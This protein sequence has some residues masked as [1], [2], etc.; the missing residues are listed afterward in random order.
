LVL[1]VTKILVYY[2][3]SRYTGKSRI[4]YCDV[5]GLSQSFVRTASTSNLKLAAKNINVANENDMYNTQEIK[6]KLQ[7]FMSAEWIP[8]S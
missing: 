3:Y 8:R 6:R 5:T 7:D 4:L 1:F 2:Y